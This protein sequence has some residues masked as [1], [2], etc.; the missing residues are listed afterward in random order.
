MKIHG[1]DRGRTGREDMRMRLYENENIHIKMRVYC[2]K[3]I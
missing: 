1:M 2:D 3:E